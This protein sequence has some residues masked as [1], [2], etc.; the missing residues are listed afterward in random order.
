MLTKKSTT[1]ND[2]MILIDYHERKSL[3]K[4]MRTLNIGNT[5]DK[6]YTITEQQWSA[7]L[8]YCMMYIDTGVLIQ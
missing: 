7:L 4:I 3:L 1:R 8:N 5:V 2:Q 6:W